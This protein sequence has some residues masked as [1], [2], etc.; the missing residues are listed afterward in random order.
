[1]VTL[2]QRADLALPNY[3]ELELEGSSY[4]RKPIII[5]AQKKKR[6]IYT[7]VFNFQR[8][9]KKTTSASDNQ[10]VS[11]FLSKAGE[12]RIA[13]EKELW[14]Q[15]DVSGL[16]FKVQEIIDPMMVLMLQNLQ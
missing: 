14:A 5:R 16:L 9:M 1:M 3:S 10:N 6:E 12:K 15:I 2:L 8:F 13:I 4:T 11:Q 7:F